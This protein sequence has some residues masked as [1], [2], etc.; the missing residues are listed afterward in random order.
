MHN[1]EHDPR[2]DHCKL[3]GLREPDGNH[4]PRG[5]DKPCTCGL[6][7]AVQRALEQKSAPERRS[8]FGVVPFP[9][10]CE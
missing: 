10:E 7:N 5:A 3:C 2:T 4:T 1:F 8:F 9:Q 6:T